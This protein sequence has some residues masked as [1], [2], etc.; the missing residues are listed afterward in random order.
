M[1][2]YSAHSI[3]PLHAY[4]LPP[5][6]GRAGGA[7]VFRALSP[8]RRSSYTHMDTSIYPFSHYSSRDT[9]SHQSA[10]SIT[11]ITDRWIDQI[12]S[13]DRYIG[14][15]SGSGPSLIDSLGGRVTPTFSPHWAGR[16]PPYLLYNLA[17]PTPYRRY[18]E[19]TYR[20]PRPINLW[21]GIDAYR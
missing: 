1:N 6:K 20:A 10:C 8:G 2:S 11:S 12:D 13:A 16:G 3:G 14:A 18:G 7:I 19:P 4:P 9:T 21:Y 5:G 17:L 15:D